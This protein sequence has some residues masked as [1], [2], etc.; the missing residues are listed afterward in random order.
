MNEDIFSKVA[1]TV[2]HGLKLNSNKT[3]LLSQK[4]KKTKEKSNKI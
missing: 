4:K 2:K 1:W 3:K